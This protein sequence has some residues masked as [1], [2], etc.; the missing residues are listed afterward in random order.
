MHFMLDLCTYNIVLSS[1]RLVPVL[2]WHA[3]LHDAVQFWN[4]K[5]LKQY[6]IFINEKIVMD[7]KRGW[8]IFLNHRF[9]NAVNRL[10]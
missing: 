4:E 5:K 6:K 3:F 8:H 1:T 9:K 7:V 2:R 10:L